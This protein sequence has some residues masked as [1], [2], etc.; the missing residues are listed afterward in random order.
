MHCYSEWQKGKNFKLQGKTER[1]KKICKIIECGKNC[2]G[3]GYC[4]KHYIDI[5]Y[6]PRIGKIKKPK[7]NYNLFKK[8]NNCGKDFK[9]SHKN[10]IFCSMNCASQKNK[11][12]YILKGGYKKILLNSHSRA[13]KKGYV[14]EHILI[15]EKIIDR[16][17]RKGEVIH[18]IDHDKKNNSPENLMLCKS[19]SEHMKF[20]N[21]SSNSIM[22]K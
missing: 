5:V 7:N 21:K 15:M 9:L 2:F 1:I 6:N 3:Y 16:A 18:H 13:D 10:A 12:P 8:C 19:H 11:K 14:F 17:L 4:K 22:R 20:H